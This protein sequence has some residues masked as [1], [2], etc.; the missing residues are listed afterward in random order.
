METRPFS[1]Y[2]VHL[3]GFSTNHLSSLVHLE[4]F[5]NKGRHMNVDDVKGEIR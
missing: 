5:E 2:V 1:S 3:K 4:F